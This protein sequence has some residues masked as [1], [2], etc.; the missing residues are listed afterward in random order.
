[1]GWGEARGG[2]VKLRR[3]GREGAHVSRWHVRCGVAGCAAL[4]A[5][6]RAN[7]RGAAASLTL[8]GMGARFV[9]RTW[10]HPAQL[11]AG[12]EDSRPGK[13]PPRPVGD[14]AAFLSLEITHKV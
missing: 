7:G 14:A 1:V 6:R 11:V 9:A 12:C 13:R 5:A 3:G 8:R 4:A 2:L 10:A